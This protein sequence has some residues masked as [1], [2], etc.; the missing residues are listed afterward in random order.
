[1]G[2]TTSNHSSLQVFWDVWRA[3]RAD[4]HSIQRRQQARL[5]E[6]VAF[7]RQ[8]SKFYAERYHDLPERIDDV[9][10]L[11]IVGKPE[12]TAAPTRVFCK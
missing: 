3:T 2:T 11:P 12:L 9:R 6:L 10:Q 5:A 7:A 4:P 1:M 8:H